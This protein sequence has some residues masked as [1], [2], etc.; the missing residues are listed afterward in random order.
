MRSNSG[1]NIIA[2]DASKDGTGIVIDASNV[3]YLSALCVS[4]GSSTGTVNIQA[5][6][7]IAPAV[8]ASGLPNP[9]HWVN[10][11]TVGTVTIT[12]AS[13]TLI[14]VFQVGY[15]WIRSSYV[16]NNGSAGTITVTLNTQGF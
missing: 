12:A 15:K 16:H 5:S 2:A 3:Q 9:S 6:N 14:P 8:D 7:D 1:V 11:A 13:T 4:T 10:I